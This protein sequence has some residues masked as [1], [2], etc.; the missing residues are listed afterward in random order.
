MNLT[1]LSNTRRC[2]GPNWLFR[3]ILPALLIALVFA[4]P[5]AAQATYS[6]DPKVSKVEWT[7]R[8]VTG[9][10]NGSIQVKAGSLKWGMDGLTHGEVVIDMTS[11]T[12]QDL[13]PEEAS[14]LVGHL[15]SKDF[16]DVGT[17]K[18]ASFVSTAVEKITAEAGKANYRLTGNL[19]IKGITKPVVFTVLARQAERGVRATGTMSFNRTLYGI[20]YRSG[21]FFDA[22]GDRMIEDMIELSFDLHAR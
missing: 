11:I 5:L 3:V 20:K 1:S 14:M 22:L 9:Q 17:Y 13:D 7:G 15:K 2:L 6:V 21:S 10:H 18:E 19:T 4:E 8:K 16:F 12:N